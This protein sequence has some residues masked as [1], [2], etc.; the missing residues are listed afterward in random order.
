MQ[1]NRSLGRQYVAR[2]GHS[3]EHSFRQIDLRVSFDGENVAVY[4]P[5]SKADMFSQLSA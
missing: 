5:D 4:A 2:V 3:S 1:S